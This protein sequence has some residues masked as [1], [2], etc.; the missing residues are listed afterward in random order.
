MWTAPLVPGIEGQYIIKNLVLIAAAIT[1]TGSL[2]HAGRRG[3][4]QEAPAATAT[5][6]VRADTPV[7]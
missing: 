6:G 3:R 1:I 5:A 4:S 7:A 2:P